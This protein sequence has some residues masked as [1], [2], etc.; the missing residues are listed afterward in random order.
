[1]E[2]IRTA[3]DLKKL[4]FRIETAKDAQYFLEVPPPGVTFLLG[5][6]GAGK[7]SLLN[8]L[9]HLVGIKTDGNIFL[10]SLITTSDPQLSQVD[11][12]EY[13]DQI[14]DN[15]SMFGWHDSAPRLIGCI[16]H[17]RFNESLPLPKDL[18]KSGF[19]VAVHFGFT[20]EEVP[21][22]VSKNIG[23][24]FEQNN[25]YAYTEF[26]NL[27]RTLGVDQSPAWIFLETL[28]NSSFSELD[29]S[30]EYTA[31]QER[32]EV[33][34]WLENADKRE[35]LSKSFRQ[36][37]E[38]LKFEFQHNRN[39]I[40]FRYIVEIPQAGPLIDL[41]RILDIEI[42]ELASKLTDGVK[43]DDWNGIYRFFPHDI[44]TRTTLPS[45][46]ALATKWLKISDSWKSVDFSHT[47]GW[48]FDQLSISPVDKVN[49]SLS[50]AEEK[51]IQRFTSSSSY[52]IEEDTITLEFKGLSE[53]RSALQLI[54]NEFQSIDIGIS[55][56][57]L[58][59]EEPDFV[60]SVNEGLK[61]PI[62]VS[63]YWKDAIDGELR[64]LLAASDGQKQIMAAILSLSS[65][66]RAAS[67]LLLIDEFDRALHPNAAKSFAVLLQKTLKRIDGIAV[68]STHNPSVTTASENENWYASR[69]ALGQFSVATTFG[70][71]SVAAQ[72][73]GVDEIDAYR[74]KRL[75]VLGEGMHEELI[76]GRLIESN[77]QIEDSVWLMTANGI[78]NYSLAWEICIR[79][80]AMPVLMVYDKRDVRLES[81]LQK[82]QSLPRTADGWTE[83]GLEE[84]SRDLK[85]SK[86]QSYKKHLPLPDGHHEL[87]KM[88]DL[89]K[90]VIRNGGVD[91]LIILGLDVPDIVDCLDP[92]KFKDVT[93]WAEAH[94]S[95]RRENLN[96]EGFKKK[97][98]INVGSITRA[99]DD[100]GLTW[101]PDL[102]KVY[103]RISEILKSEIKLHFSS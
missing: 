1:M 62:T 29:A 45:G 34:S 53:A 67:G 4:Y 36:F 99:L 71:V 12:E 20:E 89:M 10:V 21:A 86:K 23:F 61:T 66:D 55:A 93:N 31:C 15:G 48:L 52:E 24:I 76:L 8:G 56:L 42:G 57:V 46:P 90:Q 75:I 26:W 32:T 43:Q 17:H 100:P 7:S 50:Q 102:Q 64:P 44:F 79:L 41:L 18:K 84:L 80:F 91:R 40:L 101:H 39:S 35:L 77:S 11:W 73:M 9:G 85:I 95:A 65:Q 72:D 68:L 81:C 88:L 6:N 103:S 92:Q 96:G 5:K 74:L 30:D 25:P 13:L 49:D 51:F 98:G 63:I 47:E 38:N 27:P 87:G 70:D 97:H 22:V 33:N 78:N 28:A 82:L 37:C 58:N 69:D 94:E 2:L 59:I 60:F 16:N 54:S 14:D 3:A 19:D 83:S